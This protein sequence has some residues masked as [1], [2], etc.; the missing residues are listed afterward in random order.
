MEKARGGRG[1]G[2][3]KKE[4]WEGKGREKSRSRKKRDGCR[5]G[6]RRERMGRGGR[7]QEK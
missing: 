6:V 2:R 1:N 4:E 3:Q 5:R 7:R